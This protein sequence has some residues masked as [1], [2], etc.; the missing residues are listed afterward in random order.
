MSKKTTETKKATK[1]GQKFQAIES[2]VNHSNGE[3]DS[4]VIK[5]GTYDQCLKAIK[6]AFDNAGESDECDL[7]VNNFKA[8]D[9]DTWVHY[10]CSGWEGEVET[11]WQIKKVKN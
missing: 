3:H 9:P 10:E 8:D 5:T 7:D 11:T 6:K 2:T 1:A 4:D